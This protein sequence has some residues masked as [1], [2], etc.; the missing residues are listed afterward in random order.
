MDTQRLDQNDYESIHTA[1]RA[2]AAR[3]GGVRTLN[4]ML[5]R[6]LA[7]VEDVEDGVEAHAAWEYPHD[8]LC[9][10]WLA[11]AWPILTDVVREFRAGE[12]AA[13]DAR[14]TAAT[15]ALEGAG[16]AGSQPG[17]GRWWHHR[18]PRLIEGAQDGE[19]P[20]GW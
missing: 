20:P 8:L 7:L 15:V 4:A 2:L 12:L 3:Y 9:R 5:D 1:G 11:E 13:L 19:L 6:W 10:D 17:G 16:P 18:R 14:Y